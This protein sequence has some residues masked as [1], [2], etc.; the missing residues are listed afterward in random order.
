MLRKLRFAGIACSWL[1]LAACIDDGQS[2]PVEGV[3]ILGATDLAALRDGLPRLPNG[4]Y[5]VEGDIAID[6]RQIDRYLL[7][8][9]GGQGALVQWGAFGQLFGWPQDMKLDITYCVSDNFEEHKPFAMARM[10]EAVAAWS[11]KTNLRLRYVPSSDAD[12]GR[13][14]HSVGIP[15]SWGALY[16]CSD[17]DPPT[18]HKRPPTCPTGQPPDQIPNNAAP[19]S[20]GWPHGWIEIAYGTLTGPVADAQHIFKHELGHALGF[21]HEDFHLPGCTM[22]F[23]PGSRA[24]TAPDRSS[25]MSTCGD[26][27]RSP[28]LSAGDHEGA[29]KLYGH[30]E[31]MVHHSPSRPVAAKQA[32]YELVV[33]P[34]GRALRAT[35]TGS[36][37]VDL[38]VGVGFRPTL[39][40]YT[41]R[42][43]SSTAAETLTVETGNFPFG[44]DVFLM[45]Y[46]V[47]KL[48]TADLRVDF[49]QVTNVSDLVPHVLPGYARFDAAAG[50]PVCTSAAPSC[51]S[52]AAV[53][54]RGAILNGVE[55]N[56]PN[57][58]DGCP[59]GDW[60]AY[61][62][63]ESID[64]IS[65]TSA[66]GALRPGIAAEVAVDV[67]AYSEFSD[68]LH[69]YY[70]TSPVDVWQ[71]V[72]TRSPGRVGRSR[73]QIP[74]PPLGRGGPQAVRAVFS[75]GFGDPSPC[76]G[77]GYDDVDDLTF[78]TA[79]L[80]GP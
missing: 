63:D 3:S 16:R 56:A 42:S 22:N 50:T 18:Y 74:L 49:E 23:N 67:F 33:A 36:G 48:S 31:P 2:D 27:E 30:L 39:A 14:D 37:N 40:R 69:L 11:E 32:V 38:Y 47:S 21:D 72:A 9:Y 12:C 57:T 45:R 44:V 54:G 13:G 51:D 65:I 10:A 6:E 79:P 70:R 43:T 78:T 20:P 7:H 55:P 25:I 8:R 60:G 75:Y 76:P 1:S 26:A 34:G 61:G 5:L 59:D 4:A 41:A 19:A 35:T 68:Q 62:Q 17:T 73:I 77:G 29:G 15:V 28:D 52:V 46:G 80:F 66:G 53:L 24:L 71:L 58:A 64:Q